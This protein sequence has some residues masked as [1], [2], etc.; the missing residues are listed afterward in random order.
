MTAS[1]KG[2]PNHR[3]LRER[4]LRGWSQKDV[5]DKIDTDS[6][7]VGK[8]ERREITPSP[9]SRQRLCELFGKNA[10]ELGFLDDDAHQSKGQPSGSPSDTPISSV[11]FWNVPY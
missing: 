4:K 2:T 6:K 7:I 1:G 5:A 3:L 10:E 9:Y 8:W 11:L